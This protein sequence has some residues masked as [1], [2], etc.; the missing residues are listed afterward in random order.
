MTPARKR[1]IAVGIFSTLIGALQ[2]SRA[3]NNPRLS[4]EILEAGIVS[5][6]TLAQIKSPAS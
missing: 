6:L 4:D 3:V 5:A 2:M 1:E